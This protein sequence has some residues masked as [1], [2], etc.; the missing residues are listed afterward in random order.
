M[1]FLKDLKEINM[2]ETLQEI[3]RIVKPFFLFM[4]VLFLIGDIFSLLFPNESNKDIYSYNLLLL[5]YPIFIAVSLFAVFI[6]K[7]IASFLYDFSEKTS[8]HTIKF[9]N[10]SVFLIISFILLVIA[11]ADMS[12][13]Y[14][15]FLKFI[16]CITALYS[17]Y[18]KP[19]QFFFF[20]WL[21]VAVIYNPFIPLDLG[22]EIWQIVNLLTLIYIA[23]FFMFRSKEQHS[24]RQIDL[25]FIKFMIHDIATAKDIVVI[26]KF[27]V[28]YFKRICL[29]LEEKGDEKLTDF[30]KWLKIENIKE[31]TKDTY[32]SLTIEFRQ[33]VIKGVVPDNSTKCLFDEFGQFLSG[34]Y[35]DYFYK[36][37]MKDDTRKFFKLLT[38]KYPNNIDK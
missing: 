19:T 22:R 21:F 27:A 8:L 11:F 37:E 6:V 31:A 3:W 38:S 17:I 26:Y 33:Y 20:A 35:N 34:L 14:Y 16:L 5:I 30:Y 15:T 2:K 7:K 36:K 28:W 10:Q 12:R 29:L 32:M 9:S 25:S 1:N 23:S 4:L 18:L 24:S 13:G